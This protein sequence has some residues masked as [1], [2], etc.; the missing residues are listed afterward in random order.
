MREFFELEVLAGGQ[1]FVALLCVAIGLG[2]AG[3][4]WQLPYVQRLELAEGDELAADDGPEPTH[5][6]RTGEFDAVATRAAEP[7]RGADDRARPSGCRS[8]M[9][10]HRRTKIVDHDR[11]RDPHASRAWSS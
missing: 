2:I 10:A 3:A 7:R 6:P 4:A 8:A 5:T 1:W 9:S 11:P